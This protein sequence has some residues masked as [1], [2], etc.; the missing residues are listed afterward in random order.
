MTE[1][2]L[3][4]DVGN[5]SS[6]IGVY[7]GKRITRLGGIPS[8]GQTANDIRAALKRLCKRQ[9][10]HD[11]VLASVVPNATGVWSRVLREITGVP[12]LVVTHEINLGVAVSYP[13]PES[14]GADRLANASAAV[15]RYEPPIVVADFGTALT[16]DVIT[17][18][19]GY[20]GGI[21]APGLPL[22]FDYLAEKTALLPHTELTPVKHYVGKS[23]VEAM[24]LGAKFG[25][26]GAVREISHHLLSKLGE[27]KTTFCVTGG[28]AA[29][30]LR[31]LDIPIEYDRNLTLFGLGRIYD[32][33][34]GKCEA[35]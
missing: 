6:T 21:I 3:T 34:R 2:I 19:A 30:I 28:Y 20:V 5:T 14:I 9:K 24:S 7:S 16:F 22:M 25:Y 17:P 12:P 26:R 15:A 11:A 33:N 23:T 35:Q 8:K 13:R 1:K 10:F 27:D 18:R 31:G 29:N 4:V 32:L